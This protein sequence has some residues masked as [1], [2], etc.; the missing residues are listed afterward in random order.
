MHAIQD[1]VEHAEADFEGASHR[2]LAH[3]ALLSLRY[4]LAEVPW[5]ALASGSHD[6]SSAGFKSVLQQ[7]SGLIKRV[8]SLT[9]PVLALYQET[10]LGTSTGTQQS[11]HI[12]FVSKKGK[13]LLDFCR[14][15]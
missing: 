7:L 14:V 2:C 9:L 8:A 15:P 13:D 11:Y 6:T 3:G 12:Q 5:E 4:V 1:D 10:Y